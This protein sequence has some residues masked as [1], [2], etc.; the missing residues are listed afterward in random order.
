[1]VCILYFFQKYWLIVGNDV[2]DAVLS[3]FNLGHMLHKMNYTHIVLILK[4]N[5]PKK[6]FLI[7]GLLV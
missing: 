3:I 1:M 6:M 7:T 5:D 2:T 4:K